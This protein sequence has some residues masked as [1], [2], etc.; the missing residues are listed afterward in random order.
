MDEATRTLIETQNKVRALQS[1]VEDYYLAKS[2]SAYDV[3]T[4]A[5]MK[6]NCERAQYELKVQYGVTNANHIYWD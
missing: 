4:M 6:E 2:L 5:D 1:V 3:M